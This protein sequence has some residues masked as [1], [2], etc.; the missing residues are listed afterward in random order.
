[1]QLQPVARSGTEANAGE[2]VFE[3]LDV[4]GHIGRVHVPVG[5]EPNEKSSVVHVQYGDPQ[6]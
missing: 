5:A 4:G 1:L 3:G 2:H 6:V